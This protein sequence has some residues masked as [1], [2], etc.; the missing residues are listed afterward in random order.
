[1]NPAY[2]GLGLFR[3]L[4]LLG[5]IIAFENGFDYMISENT[6]PGTKHL[7]HTLPGYRVCHEV[8]FDKMTLPGTSERGDL[9]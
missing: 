8:Y 9:S 6:T 1:M 3:R 5:E 4:S 2:Q 7:Y